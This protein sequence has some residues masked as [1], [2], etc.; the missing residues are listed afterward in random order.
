MRTPTPLSERGVSTTPA[1]PQRRQREP[2]IDM[3]IWLGSSYLSGFRCSEPGDE[4]TEKGVANG[5]T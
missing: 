4:D 3:A 1:P 2:A 5:R